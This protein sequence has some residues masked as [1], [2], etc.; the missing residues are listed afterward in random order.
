MRFIFV[1]QKNAPIFVAVNEKQSKPNV[2]NGK[3]SK[4]WRKFL[5]SIRSILDDFPTKLQKI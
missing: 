1:W 2:W 5:S 3:V 4:H